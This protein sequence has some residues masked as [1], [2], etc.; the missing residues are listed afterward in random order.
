MA[1]P[2]RSAGILVPVVFLLILVRWVGFAQSNATLPAA[3]RSF[4]HADWNTAERLVRSYLAAHESSAEAHYLLALTL[5]RENRPGDSLNEYTHAARL[6]KPTAVDLRWVALDYVLLNDLT[7]ADSWA[8][9]SL[10]WQPN[11]GES[12][13]VFGRIKYEENRFSEASNAFIKSLKLSP[14]SVKAENNLGLVYQALNR[15][16]DAIAAYKQAIAWQA[17]TTPQ[18][19]QPFL[20]LGILLLDRGQFVD[21]LAL[22]LKAQAIAPRDAKVHG[23]LGKL[24]ERQG[25]LDAAQKQFEEAVKIDP[26]SA[27]VHFQLGQVYRKK[28]MAPEAKLE[29]DQTERLNGTHSS[30]LH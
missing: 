3:Q 26:D 1:R 12:W 27:A 24:Y 20:N 6:Q 30:P 15:S 14:H 21:A 18:S 13:Y 8:S 4:E 17:E 7:D 11:D 5:L 23:S 22:L 19:E 2:R 25:D 28:G 10:D 16:E 29:F 9:R